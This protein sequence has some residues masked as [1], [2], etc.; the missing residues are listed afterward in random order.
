MS[1]TNY[2]EMAVLDEIL[3]SGGG[4]GF[5]ATVYIGLSSTTPNE[6][7]GNVTEPSGN[8]YARVA[9]TN[10][11][12]NWPAASGTGGIKKN[13]TS[14][15]FPEATGDWGASLTQF[16]IFDAAQGGNLLLFD[17]LDTAKTISNGETAR[18]AVNELEVLAS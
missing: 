9:V 17:V 8:G 4:G 1:L 5:P 16:L 3:G 11:S 7:G 2:A 12:T 6:T 14:I 10:N 13:G 15:E 18:F